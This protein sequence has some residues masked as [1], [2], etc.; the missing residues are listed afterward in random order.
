ML[1]PKQKFRVIEKTT[2]LFVSGEDYVMIHTEYTSG[3]LNPSVVT[4][5]CACVII[6]SCN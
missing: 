2:V 4:S 3:E 1:L 5:F 6:F